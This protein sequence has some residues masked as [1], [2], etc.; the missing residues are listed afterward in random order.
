[1]ETQRKAGLPVHL[2]HDYNPLRL[3]TPQLTRRPTAVQPLLQQLGAEISEAEDS[4]DE[5]KTATVER[6]VSFS[7]LKSHFVENLPLLLSSND[8]LTTVVNLATPVAALSSPIHWS[9]N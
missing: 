3:S 2:P 8:L 4:P 6:K 1:M 7:K 5:D 9:H